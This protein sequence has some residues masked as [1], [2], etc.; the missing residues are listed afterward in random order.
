MAEQRVS[1]VFSKGETNETQENSSKTGQTSNKKRTIEQLTPQENLVSKQTSKRSLL[2]DG[3]SDE[4]DEEEL[5][6]KCDPS[7]QPERK[8]VRLEIK[9]EFRMEEQMRARALKD[10]F[11]SRNW[12]PFEKEELINGLRN[13]G[14]KRW[15]KVSQCVHSKSDP[16]VK[17]YIGREKRNHNYIIQTSF[18]NSD[19]TQVLIDDGGLDKKGGRPSTSN[20]AVNKDWD[21]GSIKPEGKLVEKLVRRYKDAPVEQWAEVMQNHDQQ[22]AEKRKVPGNSEPANMS[23]VLPTSLN[24]I[25]DNEKHPDPKDCGDVDY[26]EIYRYLACLCEGEAP[27]DVNQATATRISQLMPNL[28]SIC[29]KMDFKKE[30]KFLE[31]YRGLHTANTYRPDKTYD[32][33]LKSVQTILGLSAVPGLNPLGLH[34]EICVDRVVPFNQDSK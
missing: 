33:R 6:E 5:S 34:P 21:N 26:A 27:P 22:S 10:S 18:E 9:R 17:A 16:V 32:P 24:W 25:A 7:K 11:N 31:N 1:C 19:G 14:S 3:F 23:S 29:K 8:S 2:D 28:S 20:Y 30:I 4:E 13:F 15:R 12:R